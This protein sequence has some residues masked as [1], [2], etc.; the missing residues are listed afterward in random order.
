MSKREQDFEMSEQPLTHPVWEMLE[1]KRGEVLWFDF[2]EFENLAEEAGKE[3]LV[4][5]EE[6]E[7]LSC[8]L[9]DNGGGQ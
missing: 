7:A 9:N 1:E 5:E 8:C 4:T 3:P 6:W 2:S